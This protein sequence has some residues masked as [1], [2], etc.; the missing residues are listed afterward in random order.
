MAYLLTWNGDATNFDPDTRR[1]LIART[2]QF[3][4]VQGWWSVRDRTPLDPGARV[5]LL[6]Q[7]TYKG[8]IAHGHLTGGRPTLRDDWITVDLWWDAVVSTPDRLPREAVMNT[9]PNG[10]WTQARFSG[11]RPSLERLWQQQLRALGR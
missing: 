10:P 3:E 11:A 1:D 8:V 9:D 7:N 4:S 6:Q 5:F 2:E